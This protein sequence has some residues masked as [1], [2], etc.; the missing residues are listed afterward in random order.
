MGSGNAYTPATPAQ[1]RYLVQWFEEWGEM[2][3]SDFLPI[4]LK[5]FLNNK[6]NMNGLISSLD[7]CNVEDRPPSIFQCRIK[8][9]NEWSENWTQNE[10]DQLLNELKSVDEEF[11]EKF[12]KRVNGIVEPEDGFM[13]NGTAK[14]VI[15][16]N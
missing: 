1:I 9:F 15:G 4:L 14:S 6:G 11:F 3:R 10:R 16:D 13:T 8:L 2:Q 7:S 12:E 5:K